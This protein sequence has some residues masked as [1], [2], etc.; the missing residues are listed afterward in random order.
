MQAPM[1][2]LVLVLGALLTVATAGGCGHRPWE[3]PGDGWK[4]VTSGHFVVRTDADPQDY[5]PI[6]DRL[7]DVHEA[8]AVT[9][10]DGISV[11]SVDVLLFDDERDFRG[12]APGANVAGF[13]TAWPAMPQGMLVFS[14]RSEDF[15]VVAGTAV[16]ELAHRFLHAKSPRVPS[17]L[18]EGFAR[19]VGAISVDE[20]L[21]VF[22]ADRIHG[23]YVYFAD[24][25]PLQ[26]L[27]SA[28]G[29]DFHGK[30]R[31]AH[32]M[33][34]WWLMRQ[35][36]GNPRPDTMPRFQRLVDRIAAANGPAAQ[37]QAISEVF[38]GLPLASVEKA[39]MSAH[40]AEYHGMGR[41][42]A[43]RTFAVTLRRAGRASLRVENADPRAIKALCLQL[44]G[45]RAR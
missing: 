34:A 23:G 40:S 22:D 30:E 9:F 37:A 16:H 28:T 45:G 42:R 32:Y 33:T 17:W 35:L 1:R 19:Y 5:Q 10:F 43:R 11:P 39:I 27:L 15:D 26:S 2:R 14:A 18:H 24:P 29:S 41:E 6:I 8:L 38:D 13:F 20:D 12:V 7:E 21:V 25:V 44:R 36:F 4:V 31:L 3:D